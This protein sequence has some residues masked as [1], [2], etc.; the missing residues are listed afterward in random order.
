MKRFFRILLVFALML[1]L[2]A[3][4]KEAGFPEVNDNDKVDLTYD[5]VLDEFDGVAMDNQVLK[6]ELDADIEAEGLNVSLDGSAH[7]GSGAVMLNLKLAGDM[8]E[9]NLDGEATIYA[10]N[11]GLYFNGAVD[12]DAEGMKM[13]IEGKYKLDDMV[14]DF[15]DED[16]D[17]NEFLELDFTEMFADEQ[18]KKLVEEYEGLTFYKN[19]NKFQLKLI[20]TNELLLANKEL[21]LELLDMGEPTDGQEI[22]LEFVLTIEDKKLTALGV[23][24]DLTDPTEDLKVSLT[25][26]ANVVSEMPEFPTDLEEYEPFDMMSLF[27]EE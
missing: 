19:G 13:S 21:L 6:I 25:L 22:D 10:N 15:F 26:T 4:N 1:T 12:I 18:F 11:T 24:L 8:P 20:V 3:C 17:L 7:F 2:A 16:I 14:D 23:R 5:D 27:M 9:G